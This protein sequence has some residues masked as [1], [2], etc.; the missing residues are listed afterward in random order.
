MAFDIFSQPQGPNIDV[1]LFANNATAGVRVGQALGTPL[2]NAI[3][4]GIKGILTGQQIRQNE[5]SIDN[6]EAQAE[7]NRAR[8]ENIP[9][10]NEQKRLELENQKAVAELN[11]MK[12]ELAQATQADEL[13][14]ERLLIE[15]QKAKLQQEKQDR[16][17]STE[18]S[19]ILT[20]GTDQ[21]KAAL[22]DNPIVDE[23]IRKNPGQG[24]SIYGAV[25][26][27]DAAKAD[28]AFRQNVLNRL[29]AEKEVQY[30]REKEK[31]NA[32]A[33][34]KQLETGQKA[35]DEVVKD[36]RVSELLKDRS[37]SD[38]NEVTFFPEG[39]VK[40]KD[41]KLTG[42]KQKGLPTTNSSLAVDRDGRVIGEGYTN[43][44]VEKFKALQIYQSK[45]DSLYRSQNGMQPATPKAYRLPE[46]IPA[47]A[48]PEQ[49]RSGGALE[50]AND[51]FRGLTGRVDDSTG[52]TTTQ[53]QAAR[54]SA[55]ASQTPVAQGNGDPS[56]PTPGPGPQ[57]LASPTRAKIVQTLNSVTPPVLGQEIAE[58]LAGDAPLRPE[59]VK[60]NVDQ[61]AKKAASD[62][63]RTLSSGSKEEK[64][65][66]RSFAERNGIVKTQAGF[67][68]YYEKAVAKGLEGDFAPEREGGFLKVAEKRNAAVRQST[69]QNVAAQASIQPGQISTPSEPID[70]AQSVNAVADQLGLTPE[71][72]SNTL[73]VVERV[74][75]VKELQEKPAYVKALAAVE[76]AGRP[77]AVSP[78]GVKGYLQVTQRVANS[79]GLD[80]NLPED[81]ILA[82]QYYIEDLT[83]DFNGN[84]MLAYAAYNTGPAPIKHA[85]KL[86]QS[87]DWREVKKFLFPALKKYERVIGVKAEK[88]ITE[89]YNYPERVALYEAIYNGGQP[90]SL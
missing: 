66:I 22:I 42:E 6:T 36:A 14:K 72:R 48:A 7:L 19:R 1:N 76:S 68:A 25:L 5:A 40:V 21:E 13:E 18:I 73:K 12:L 62:S 4:G 39:S 46:A 77:N 41:G 82:G 55:V 3:D 24:N 81:N 53:P 20:T 15:S 29:D 88:K 75:S 38:V 10:E 83:K 70:L 9:I 58:G 63:I 56:A 50:Y 44:Q 28:P 34:Q 86:A 78:T 54:P 84:R 47:A 45:Q 43:T 51:I 35:L 60:A 33:T 23:Y 11:K 17:T 37:L 65:A 32:I 64:D 52:Q 89:T 30:Q 61:Y 26:N 80:R 67:K 87:D 2:S 57:P 59:E 69:E 8:V 16:L 49:G 74:N 31:E 90:N 85:Q 27:T 79:Y 71:Q